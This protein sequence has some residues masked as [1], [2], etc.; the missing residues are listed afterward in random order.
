[1]RIITPLTSCPTENG[2][3]FVVSGTGKPLRQ[4]IY[5]FDLAKLF[6]WMIREY[7]DVEPVIFSGWFVQS[8]TLLIFN[9]T[10]IVAEDEEV[11]IKELADAIVKS[12]DFK[13]EYTVCP[14]I[15]LNALHLLTSNT[16]HSS[17]PVV[18]M[19]NSASLRQTKSYFL[20]YPVAKVEKNHLS[21]HLSMKPSNTPLVG[22]CRTMTMLGL[23]MSS[24]RND[25][26]SYGGKLTRES[27]VTEGCCISPTRRKNKSRLT[28]S[29]Q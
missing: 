26:V 12:I 15:F 13:G 3:P 7:D 17:I 2:T 20:C 6:I 29:S 1:M 18:R 5:S 22:S 9:Q 27:F 28:L 11:S 14:F 4:F 24:L 8:Y 10:E 23:A 16:C 19:A 25:R 21:S